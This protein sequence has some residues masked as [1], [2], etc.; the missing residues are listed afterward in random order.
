MTNVTKLFGNNDPRIDTMVRDLK[1]MIYERSS[2]VFTLATVLGIL[3]MV[4]HDLVKDME[5]SDG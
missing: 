1:D 2:G 4:A 3:Q 5:N